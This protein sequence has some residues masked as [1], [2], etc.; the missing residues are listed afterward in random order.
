[1]ISKYLQTYL[2]SQ[3][4]PSIPSKMFSPQLCILLS[5][6]LI[7]AVFAGKPALQMRVAKNEL[8]DLS[9]TEYFDAKV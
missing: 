3:S 8:S 7:Q 2:H 5:A 6:V 4:I 9:K 1:M